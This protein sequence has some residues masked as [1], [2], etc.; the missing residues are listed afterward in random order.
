MKVETSEERLRRLQI[1][2]ADWKA[3][4]KKYEICVE[5]FVRH[6]KSKKFLIKHKKDSYYYYILDQ[7]KVLLHQLLARTFIRK[8]YPAKKVKHKDGNTLNNDLDNLEWEDVL[9]REQRKYIW[10]YAQFW[11]EEITPNEKVA[12]R[13][14][15]NNYL[16]FARDSMLNKD[17]SFG[18]AFEICIIHHT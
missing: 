17:A 15:A 14:M 7:K 10:G 12:I 1:K 2:F 13:K 16:Y 6:K 8:P 18:E 4:D 5:G 11:H 3:I 9:S